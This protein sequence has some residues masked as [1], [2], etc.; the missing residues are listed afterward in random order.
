MSTNTSVWSMITVTIEEGI[1]EAVDEAIRAM[2]EDHEA[3][4]EEM[5]EDTMNNAWIRG[6]A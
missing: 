4:P 1:I 5:E 2:L 3:Q 6:N